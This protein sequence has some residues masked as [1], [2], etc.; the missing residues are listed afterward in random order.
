MEAL[1]GRS[2]IYILFQN[3]KVMP[4]LQI[5]EDVCQK[6]RIDLAVLFLNAVHLLPPPNDEDKVYPAKLY[7]DWLAKGFV[8][9]EEAAGLLSHR[10]ASRPGDDVVIWSLL[11]GEKAYHSPE[12]FWRSRYSNDVDARFRR[13]LNTGFL[14][15]SAPRIQH[16]KGLSW[17][18][19]RPT[20]DRASGRFFL[21]GDGHRTK[22]ASLSKKGLKGV[23]G[24]SIFP[25][26]AEAGS[27][28]YQIVVK[29]FLQSMSKRP[30]KWVVLLQPLLDL[31]MNHPTAYRYRGNSAS[32]PLFGVCVSNDHKE[33]T[34]KGVFEWD[35]R[36]SLPEFHEE[37]IWLV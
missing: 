36:I 31:E 28:R 2:H 17:A 10:Q 1:R 13:V 33:W 16:Q 27:D 5:L 24:V 15:S 4:F 12:S 35:L 29:K 11:V 8:S 9:V 18:P 21:G 23:F 37:E 6:G 32:L 7:T 30:Y 34:W 22:L 19:A 14:F 25:Y 20:C 3:D 26:A